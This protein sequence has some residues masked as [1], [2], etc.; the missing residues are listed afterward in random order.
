[1]IGQTISHYKILEKL[2][3]GGMGVVYK[4]E[5]TDLNRIVALKFLPPQNSISQQDNDRF[6]REAQTAAVLNHPNV[7]TI[8]AIEKDESSGE[9]RQFIVM[10]YM[11]GMTLREKLAEGPLSLDTASQF[12]IQIGEALHEAHLKNIVHRDI[13][14]DNVMVTPKNKIKV[15]DFGLAKLKGSLKL[16]RTSSTVGTL[17]YMAPEQIQ[18]GEVDSRSDIF[19]FGVLFYEML[20]GHMPFRGE[21]QAAMVYSIVNEPA[22]SI[23]RYLPDA[24]AELMNIF[25]KAL[26]KDPDQRYQTAIDM[27]VDIR[28]LKKQTS[29]ITSIRPLQKDSSIDPSAVHSSTQGMPVQKTERLWNMPV[30]WQ[31]AFGIAVIAILGMF[32][33]KTLEVPA[34]LT[35]VKQIT[36][37]SGEEMQPDVSPDGNY[38]VFVK[39]EKEG[40]N[41]YLQRIGGGN[42]IN[43]T[44]NSMTVNDFPVFSPNGDRIVF[45][46][47]RD[48]GGLF[49]M[50]STGESVRRLTHAG[51]N[52]SWSPDGKQIVYS[53]EGAEQ[54][55]SR[56]TVSQ[57]WIV[58]VDDGTQRK[59]YDGDAIQ[60][61]WS[62]NG[63]RIA[64]W[65]LPQGTGR[66][67]LWTVDTDG[68][69][70]VRITDDPDVDWIPSWSANGHHLYF[71]S[72]RG[73]TMNVWRVGIDERSGAVSGK[74]EPVTVPASNCS[75]LTLSHTGQKIVYT[76]LE[77]RTNIFKMG[78]DPIAER[79]IPPAVQITTG[80]KTYF[81]IDISPDGKWIATAS[82][83]IQE[84]IYTLTT[85]GAN[86]RR[87]TDDKAKDRG[88]KWFP[89][90]KS[91]LF[92]SDRMQKY[93][94]WKINSDGSG[95]VQVTK[96]DNIFN[97][98][99]LFRDGKKMLGFN[100]YTTVLVDLT[101]P[102]TERIV[103]ELPK[104]P[105]T[106]T[107]LFC[108]DASPDGKTLIGARQFNDGSAH[109][110]YLYT[111]GDNTFQKVLEYGREPLWVDGTNKVLFF[112]E[113]K[114]MLLNRSANRVKVLDETLSWGK[115]E[116]RTLSPDQRTL[117]FIREESES[118][119]WQASIE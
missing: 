14:A 48:G 13:K 15:M 80:S 67:D 53:T 47:E 38:I 95:L 49:V 12:A 111:V 117:Y 75:W 59:I 33:F 107:Y 16:T 40:R 69:N 108:T 23:A 21:H 110:L 30:F 20:T 11:E 100:H 31:G 6:V 114:L 96:S 84:D 119:I 64:F 52:P 77:M 50:G 39:Q 37:L 9:K 18:G 56:G 93:E 85:D 106:D 82:S 81:W 7:C 97:N 19:S 44:K 90:G 68:K 71:L 79:L 86:L 8:F 35:M 34:A 27:V 4:A 51:F 26:E 5:D 118:D 1:M 41:I 3:E 61:S 72:D 76:S 54:P 66:R 2:G 22:E 73:G 32:F 94:A 98:P 63:Y 55:F 102:L 74:P 17:A 109:G 116:Y 60:P 62:P 10:E 29:K 87:L 103:S 113:G 45:R 46:S 24:S 92:Y 112:S 43:L 88:P 99:V 70:P 58:N 42:P 89:D 115:T 57:L 101:K 91:L 36:D 65:G 83:G 78:F 105:S 28:R 104:I 25:A